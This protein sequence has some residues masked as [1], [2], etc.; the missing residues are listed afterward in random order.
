MGGTEFPAFILLLATKPDSWFPHSNCFRVRL[1]SFWRKESCNVYR[2]VVVRS[3]VTLDLANW[4]GLYACV[5]LD[6]SLEPLQPSVWR[7]MFTIKKTKQRKRKKVTFW[8]KTIRDRVGKTWNPRCKATLF[9]TLYY[10]NNVGYTNQWHV[11][12]GLETP[13]SMYKNT[14]IMKV[15][16]QLR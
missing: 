7:A 2:A 6:Y 3:Q 13:S 16:Y 12:E 4:S 15:I 9:N 8:R 5:C 14:F 1:R 10:Q 11:L